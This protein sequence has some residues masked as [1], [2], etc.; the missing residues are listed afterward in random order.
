MAEE[1]AGAGAHVT[2]AGTDAG[3]DARTDART[4]AEKEPDTEPGAGI[5]TGI[6]TGIDTEVSLNIHVPHS[7][8][9]YDYFLGGTTNFPPDREAAGRALAVFPYA[10]T[11]ARANRGF[12]RRSIRHLAES[13]IE[14]FLDIGTGIPT[15]P[16]LHEI[17]QRVVPRARVMY[18]DNDPI[19]LIHAEA[20][21]QGTPEGFTAYVQA[22]VNEPEALLDAARDILDF[23]EPIALSMN[24]LLHFV[25]ERAHQITEVFKAQLPRGSALAISHLT[26]AFAPEETERLA[27]VYTAAG[28]PTRARDRAEFARFFSGWELLDPGIVATPR[29]RPGQGGDGDEPTTDPEASCYGAVAV[30]R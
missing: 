2:D 22:D 5:D 4:D 15:S 16:N 23:T 29:W 21:L 10:R 17:A 30:R 19:V 24:A 27:Q 8:R 12:M 3:T 6:G 28:T 26:P 9:M 25:P 13:G 14:Q 7:A 11:A 1:T 18:A 20:L